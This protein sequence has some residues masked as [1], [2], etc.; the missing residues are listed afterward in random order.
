MG[1]RG[2]GNT[3]GQTGEEFI[4]EKGV[5]KGLTN[6]KEGK[7]KRREQLLLEEESSM[8]D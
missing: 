6:K 2:G 1:V 8:L 3:E 5:I 4:E 7:E